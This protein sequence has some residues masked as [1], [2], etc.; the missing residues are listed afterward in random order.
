MSLER[1]K[2][3][4]L[5]ERQLCQLLFSDLNVLENMIGSR[6]DNNRSSALLDLDPF[7][8]PH[9]F[10][11]Q[12]PEFPVALGANNDIPVPGVNSFI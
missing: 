2:V 7:I 6:Q 9:Q 10:S 1:Q 11:L 8:R 4:F 5:S 3:S 12:G